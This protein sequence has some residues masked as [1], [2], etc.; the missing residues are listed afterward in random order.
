MTRPSAILFDKDGTLFDFQLSWGTWAAGFIE[1][2]AGGDPGRA[3]RLAEALDYDLQTRRFAPTSVVIAETPEVIGAELAPHLEGLSASEIAARMNASA[4]DA[5]LLPVLPLAPF[6]KDLRARGYAVGLATNDA[7]A[8]ARAHLKAEAIV[9]LF[10]FLAGYDSGHGMKP[11]PGMIHAFAKAVGVPEAAV[12][13][14]GDS[15]H[16]LIAGRAAGALCAG[17][18]TG[19]AS[20]DDLAPYADVVLPDI[21]HLPGWLERF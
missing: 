13:M 18:L 2:L 11:A 12:V 14:V 6:L 3:A 15:R 20:A 8:P 10:D 16:D 19:T 5:Q 1:D 7:E 9:E 4:A 21:A 17:V